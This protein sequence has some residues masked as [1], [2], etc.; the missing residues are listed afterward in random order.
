M[1]EQWSNDTDTSTVKASNVDQTQMCESVIMIEQCRNDTDMSTVK[2][3]NINQ[4]QTG[5]NF[6]EQWSNDTDTSTA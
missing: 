4:N 2:A 1:T 3:N 6:S 5:R